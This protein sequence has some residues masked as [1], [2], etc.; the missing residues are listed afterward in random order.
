[1]THNNCAGLRPRQTDAIA[2]TIRFKHIVSERLPHHKPTRLVS[3]SESKTINQYIDVL[4]SRPRVIVWILPL[5]EFWLRS[6]TS[7]PSLQTFVRVVLLFSA[8]D[9]C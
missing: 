1:M 9:D 7:Q 6:E 5:P 4:I 2:A 8:R 3:E